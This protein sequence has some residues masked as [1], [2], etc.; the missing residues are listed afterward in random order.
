MLIFKHIISP[1]QNCDEI[2]VRFCKLLEIRVTETTL[3]KEISEHPDYPSLLSVSEVFHLFKIDHLPLKTTISSFDSFSAPF[4]VQINEQTSGQTLF[5]IVNKVLPD[6]MISW[7]HPEKKKNE[8]IRKEEFEK[9]FTGY[10]ML[11]KANE[12]SGE[13]N[14]RIKRKEEKFHNLRNLFLI[15]ALPTL[16]LISISCTIFINGISESILPVCYILATLAGTI[17]SALL[18]LYEIDQ[19]NPAFQKICHGGHKTNCGAI[20]NSA[21][22]HIWGI[23][24]SSIGFTYFF[25]TFIALLVTGLVNTNMLFI[26]AFCN[27][28]SIPYIFFSIFY[29]AK[30][31]KQWCPMCLSVQIVF[32]LQFLIS[33]LGHFL[34]MPTLNIIPIM[35]GIAACFGF[36]FLFVQLLTSFLKKTKECKYT[37]Q[38]INRLK[39]NP[40]IFYALLDRQKELK[41]P[42]NN[43]GI[44]L[45][46]PEART[47]LVMVSDPYC[48]PCAEAHSIF[49]ELM[50]NNSDLQLQIIF[51]ASGERIDYRNLPVQHLLA[52][53]EK[54]NESLTKQSLDDWYMMKEKDYE[55][56]SLK[57]PIKDI[58]L[59]LQIERIK[60]MHRWNE[61][62]NITFTPTLFINGNQLP[63]IYNISD[64]YYFLLNYS[65]T[66]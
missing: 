14:Y 47:K 5:A 58:K 48:D 29:Q 45:G 63:E 59:T 12:M 44:V 2:V 49:D 19:H 24:W 31:A 52:I 35:L 56:F 53:A 28:M 16:L 40:D 18:L 13:T 38:E 41:K 26:V 4:I 32:V 7:Y 34:L 42:L 64:I 8:H 23:S 37:Q 33:L 65:Y 21:A 62:E 1:L 46:N 30:V 27:L 20:L 11:A 3:K 50:R 39:H 9:L 10:V 61:N 17:I 57:Y 55:Q 15:L 6:G 36:A 25:G 60:E 66:K 54:G 22:S 51:T 43:L